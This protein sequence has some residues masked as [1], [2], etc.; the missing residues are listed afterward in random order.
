MF[1]KCEWQSDW[2]LKL[3]IFRIND[4][5]IEAVKRAP[6]MSLYRFYWGDIDVST[7]D[8][9]GGRNGPFKVLITNGPSSCSKSAWRN[10][11]GGGPDA[12]VG[13]SGSV[14]WW[15]QD[16]CPLFTLFLR[17]VFS[18]PSSPT[19]FVVYTTTITPPLIHI[20]AQNISSWCLIFTFSKQILISA[21]LTC[22]WQQHLQCSIILFITIRNT[23]IIALYYHFPH[24]LTFYR[25][26]ATKRWPSRKHTSDHSNT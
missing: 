1:W 7:E 26:G 10:V 24:F 11:R 17:P 18:R 3:W 4:S 16:W 21:N 25:R 23:Q 8:V 22:W 20:N 9:M 6:E 14:R 5:D 12:D 2:K 13:S 19:L 15:W